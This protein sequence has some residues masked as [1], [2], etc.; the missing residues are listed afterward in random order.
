MT[1]LAIP[2][3]AE[4][5]TLDERHHHVKALTPRSAAARAMPDAEVPWAAIG[6]LDLDGFPAHQRVRAWRCQG[7][8][9]DQFISE[10]FWSLWADII[11]WAKDR[12]LT[13]SIQDW[14]DACAADTDPATSQCGALGQIVRDVALWSPRA[15][16]ELLGLTDYVGNPVVLKDFHVK[17]IMAMRRSY[18]SVEL[19]PLE[20]G[21][22]YLGSIVVTLMD[23][24]EWN[25]ATEGRVYWNRPHVVKWMKELLDIIE[26]NENLH[27]LFPWVRR[28]QK[29]EDGTRDKGF[30]MWST[31]GFAI[32]GRTVTG[33]SFEP[34]TAN[35][36]PKGNRYSRIGV[37]DIVDVNNAT[38]ISTQ[39][40]LFEWVTAG[41]MTMRQAVGPKSKY[42]TKWGSF[43]LSGTLYAHGDVNNQIFTLFQREKYTTLRVDVYVNG[44]DDTGGVIW[45]EYRNASYIAEMLRSMTLGPFNMRV[46]N[47][48][49]GRDQQVFPAETVKESFYDGLQLPPYVFGVVPE[50]SRGYIGFDPGSGHITKDSKN[51]AFAVYYEANHV[52]AGR[53]GLLGDPFAREPDPDMYHHVVEWD[54]LTGYSFTR[55]CDK[56]VELYD[57]YLVPIAFETNAL[58]TSY[59]EY[60]TRHHPHVRMIGAPTQYVDPQDGVEGFEPLFRNR[61]VVVHAA[62]APKNKMDMLYEELTSWKGNDTDILMAL[63][64]AKSQFQKRERL[65]SAPRLIFKR[66]AY[67][68]R[69]GASRQGFVNG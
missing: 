9:V 40:R 11:E 24:C 20:H 64:I 8:M 45:P 4:I 10:R 38:Q 7:R 57:R 48:L 32:G 12:V 26:F 66:P 19:L 2:V 43:Y 29:Y 47:L 33:R 34:L 58:Q 13:R 59:A 35:Q 55:Q 18:N 60:M 5:Y 17:A 39:K 37:D 42:R 50:R 69:F 28:P 6:I 52:K 23:F 49:G 36:F 27:K 14:V 31:A 3:E 53:P 30:G 67:L 15:F 62:Q 1:V 68:N 56:L 65:Q 44:K 21:K 61:R 46:R 25:N 16:V 41:A 63:W 54:R 51:P 22:S